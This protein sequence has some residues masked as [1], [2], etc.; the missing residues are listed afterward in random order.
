MEGVL[1]LGELADLTL[2]NDADAL[3]FDVC[4]C[5][6]VALCTFFFFCCMYVFGFFTLPPTTQYHLKFSINLSIPIQLPSIHLLTH[7]TTRNFLLSIIFVC[8]KLPP[9]YPSSTQ[10]MLGP[11]DIHRSPWSGKFTLR[12][13]F[14]GIRSLAFH[15]TES[16]LITASEDHLL[17]LWNLQKTVPYKRRVVCWW[18]CDGWVVKSLVDF[19]A[20]FD[21]LP[22]PLSSPI[23]S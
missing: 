7:P 11:K 6:F 23:L 13:H 16:V 22:S 10:Q 5:V 12:S 9:F 14:D 18:L 17:K 3:S 4:V 2:T 15:P 19:H 21:G 1:G 8:S 20:C